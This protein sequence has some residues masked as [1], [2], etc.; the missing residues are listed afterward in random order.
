M[1][2]RPGI[3]AVYTAHLADLHARL[4]DRGQNR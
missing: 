3:R 4:G 1:P 2:G